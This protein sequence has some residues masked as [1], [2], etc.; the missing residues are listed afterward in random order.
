M[1]TR[2]LLCRA[3]PEECA[4]YLNGALLADELRGERLDEWDRIVVCAP[5][6]RADHYRR[7]FALLGV[8]PPVLALDE[9]Q[10][11]GLVPCGHLAVMA[12]RRP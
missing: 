3:G 11:R 7:A 4:D 10:L 8:G 1:R 2:T 12:R 5:G 9:R 6:R